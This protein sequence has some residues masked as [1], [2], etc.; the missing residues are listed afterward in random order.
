VKLVSGESLI[1]IALTGAGFFAV[2]CGT[3][4]ETV[5]VTAPTELSGVEAMFPLGET[6]AEADSVIAVVTDREIDV[7]F[8][9]GAC[10]SKTVPDTPR[11]VVATYEATEITVTISPRT[12][13][14][15]GGYEDI[16]YVRALRL[17]LSESLDDR[18]IAVVRHPPD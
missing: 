11:R 9:T 15:D 12:P 7:A 1:A 16:G 3:K 18:S 8:M 17:H 14:C 2:G 10:T 4:R 13:D 6:A 5:E